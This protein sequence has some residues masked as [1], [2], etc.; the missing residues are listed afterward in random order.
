MTKEMTIWPCSKIQGPDDLLLTSP[1][2]KHTLYFGL[3]STSWPP[4]FP[5]CYL[6]SFPLSFSSQW[7]ISHLQ[8]VIFPRHLTF[9][10]LVRTIML[11]DNQYNIGFIIDRLVLLCFLWPATSLPYMILSTSTFSPPPPPP[12]KSLRSHLTIFIR[13]LLCFSVWNQNSLDSVFQI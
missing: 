4:F 3:R 6:F 7:S 2:M 11:L 8:S 12:P 9:L 10:S 1:H 13:L 5:A